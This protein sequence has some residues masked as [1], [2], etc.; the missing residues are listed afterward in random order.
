MK[1]DSRYMSF[2][3]AVVVLVVFA[4]ATSASGRSEETLIIAG[5]GT[6]IGTMKLMAEGFQKQRPGITVTVL[7]SIGSSGGIRA[8]AEDKIGIALSNRP[9]NA[10]ERGVGI[11]EEA[12]GRTAVIFGVQ[13]SNSAD[14]LTLSEIK[15]IYARK[16]SAWL[17]GTPIRLVLRPRTDTFSAYMVSIDPGLK[18]ASEKAYTIPGVFVGMTD[19][20]AAI[21]IEKTPG[22]FGITSAA[23][24]STEKRK[25][26]ALSV[27]GTAPTPSNVAAGKYPYALTLFL[28]YK[29]NKYKGA[30]KDF[31]E[32]V[33]SRAGRK[34]LL[35]HGHVVLLRVAGRAK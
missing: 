14:G 31:V 22:A 32:F 11:I 26:K 7:S 10:E 12:Y 30:V 1:P 33:F 24:V 35:H 19:Q 9:L 34:L 29:R 6:G 27:E 13:E 21:Q 23:L 8:V 3:F 28:V 16:R 17:D 2:V 5:A 20:E 15:E 18:S 25:I 4:S